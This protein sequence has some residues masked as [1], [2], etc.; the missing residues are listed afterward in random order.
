MR[1][2][3]SRRCLAVLAALRILVLSAGAQDDALRREIA[4]SARIGDVAR[5]QS[6][7]D[8]NG[9]AAGYWGTVAML[10]AA[11]LGQA[12]VLEAMLAGGARPNAPGRSGH[13]PFLLAVGARSLPSVRLLLAAGAD[14]NLSGRCTE[15]NCT[16][17]PA[18][19]YAAYLGEAEIVKLLL[20][21]GAEVGWNNHYATKQVDLAGRAEIYRLLLDAGGQT[22]TAHPALELGILRADSV[23]MK[24]AGLPEAA[25][26]PG[27]GMAE[28]LPTPRAKAASPPSGAP[29]LAVIA[30]LE[31]R[32]AGDLLVAEL[33]KAGGYTLV[34]R[35]EL[36]RLLVEREITRTF[37]A[38]PA[39][40]GQ[41]GELLR[42]EILVL[43]RS[44][45]AGT[46]HV[47]ESRVVRVQPGVVLDTVYR[48]A[49]LAASAE[50]A[51]QMA[52]R[53]RALGDPL[54]APRAVALSM[55]QLRATRGGVE[56]RSLEQQLTL[57]VTHRLVHHP[58]LMVL[59]R[60]ALQRLA[61]EADTAAPGG[62]WAGAFFVDGSIDPALDGSDALVVQMR[63]Q[64]AG[65][66]QDRTFVCRGSRRNLPAL[67]AELTRALAGK[68]GAPPS[69]NEPAGAAEAQVYA[70][71]A[72][73]LSAAKLRLPATAAADTAWALGAQSESLARLRVESRL[74]TIQWQIWNIG[75]AAQRGVGWP[76]PDGY[77]LD[78]LH[79]PLRPADTLPAAEFL[80]VAQDLLEAWLEGGMSP[81]IRAEPRRLEEWRTLGMRAADRAL[82]AIV[83]IDRASV[84]VRYAENLRALKTALRS[85][86]AL[87]AEQT[88]ATGDG[89]AF[90]ELSRFQARYAAAWMEEDDAF[91][92][93]VRSLRA[94]FDRREDAFDRAQIREELAWTP[95]RTYEERIDIADYS[96]SGNYSGTV[97]WIRF[98]VPCSTRALA[99]LETELLS[100]SAPEDRFLGAIL[101]YERFPRSGTPLQIFDATAEAFWDL[102]H[103]IAQDTRTL[104]TY[105]ESIP[106]TFLWVPIRQARAS[107]SGPAANPHEYSE[108]V[109]KLRREFFLAL[110]A[111]SEWL[112]ESVA[113]LLDLASFTPA[114]TAQV[115]EAIEQHLGRPSADSRRSPEY[116]SAWR[117]WVRLGPDEPPKP[118]GIAELRKPPAPLP[119]GALAPDAAIL[120]VTTRFDIDTLGFRKEGTKY[121]A[122][123]AP[124]LAEDA[125]WLFAEFGSNDEP[126]DPGR[127]FVVRLALPSLEPTIIPL[128]PLPASPLRA[129]SSITRLAIT[130]SHIAIALSHRSLLLYDRATRQWQD[131]PEIKPD[132]ILLDTPEALYLAVREDDGSG[133]VRFDWAQKRAE[134]LTSSRRNPPVSPLDQP[135]LK[136]NDL[137][138]N[139]AGEILVGAQTPD[140]REQVCWAW[141]PASRQ[142]RETT[143]AQEKS[144]RWPGLLGFSRYGW[145]REDDAAGPPN[146]ARRIMMPPRKEQGE[147]RGLPLR[148]E[149]APV[150]RPFGDG[151]SSVLGTIMP[152][153]D[154]RECAQGFVFCG[155]HGRY[156]FLPRELF[157]RHVQ[158]ATPPKD[159]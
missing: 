58:G 26:V 73:W 106:S 41:V 59:E 115:R 92:Q 10:N 152:P 4:D 100:A 63:L 69:T 89:A 134:L 72:A 17:H 82:L 117:R 30:D 118:P 70:D 67:V 114:E 128:P 20:A 145:V 44:R 64:P 83:A 27:I 150:V 148:A 25:G 35:D 47:V 78:L 13:L 135:R 15:A 138:Q 133:V 42:A 51:P 131:F 3:P 147:L 94:R 159:R 84:Q 154:W 62:F 75:L 116:A 12:T 139:G 6:L 144:L 55:L 96:A 142:W 54:T 103:V 113:N 36:E 65:G 29:R 146:Y 52:A 11:Q 38:D 8:R 140:G 21:H 109:L 1:F 110:C 104:K 130:P 108:S 46:S 141:S 79:H 86:V 158:A 90:G 102:R 151:E 143:F 126:A 129:Q 68:L 32:A 61:Q 111:E 71:E 93:E 14:P 80:E 76:T 124:L 155:T 81:A 99:A 5:V 149:F 7:V 127:G 112:D 56:N 49:P 132:E 39:N 88:P 125:L 57:A 119:A 22:Y 19:P 105:V 40:A 120:K 66:G 77:L 18:L 53:I 24:R 45:E 2:P 34:E 153:H 87:L 157:E 91:L 37:A 74:E 31:N 85:T 28:L 9:G 156:W 23:V 137:A 121:E 43:V 16:L 122:S 48:P 98:P 123:D 136:L 97:S 95:R 107:S 101:R 60:T 33:T 50:W